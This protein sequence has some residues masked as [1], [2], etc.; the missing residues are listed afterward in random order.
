[1]CIRDRFK[2]F[3]DGLEETNL[4]EI[5]LITGA[6][7]FI[8]DIQKKGYEAIIVSDSHPNYVKKIAE[9]IFQLEYISLCDKPNFGKAKQYLIDRCFDTVGHPHIDTDKESFFVIGDTWLGLSLIHI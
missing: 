5:P 6:K 9:Q 7:E 1:M 2:T 8:Q 4:A 3:K